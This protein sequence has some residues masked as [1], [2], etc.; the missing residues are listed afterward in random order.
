MRLTHLFLT[1]ATAFATG[2]TAA[3][4]RAQEGSFAPAIYVNDRVITGYEL[5]QR[6]AFLELLRFP[7]D[8]PAEAEKG[9]IEDR[10]RLDVAEAAGIK[11]S[12]AELKAG[13]AEFAARANLEPEQFIEAIAQGGVAA[14]TFRDFVAAGLAW[15]SA[16][17]ER[18]VAR[19]LVT[20]AEIDRELSADYGR[21]AGP[22][23]LI[24]EIVLPAK[25]GGFAPVRARAEE[26]AETIGSEASFAEA[27]RLNSVAPS[28]DNGGRLDWIP[29]SNLPPQV[30]AELAKIGSG[31]VTAPVPVPGGIGL[32]L[33]RGIDEGGP[34]VPAGAIAVDY[35]LFHL[36]AGADP[37]A[38]LARLRGGADTCDD[39][40]RLAR[41]Q[42]PEQLQRQ[43]A[44]RPQVPGDILASL[45]TLDANEMTLYRRAGG[46]ASVLMLCGRNATIA[47]AN[48]PLD[49]GVAP[50]TA[51]GVPSVVETVGYGNGPNRDQVREEI[52]NRKL[53]QLAEAWLAEL[54]AEALIRR[55]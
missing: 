45:D 34:E 8:I 4:T 51:D 17:R 42:P 24:S 7:G 50:T 53:S 48:V 6:I 9:L 33:L 32:F 11:V 27:A 22:R 31:G 2:L 10:L 40:F 16:V 38:E 20:P 26:L 19:V 13:M 18:F 52:T 36:A 54:K 14:E 44:L 55:P 47:A 21:G 23:V 15:R 49:V 1:L 41:G 43:R 35:A 30:R 29:L 37:A 25:L 39:L 3:A 28:R 5:D 12:D 46:G